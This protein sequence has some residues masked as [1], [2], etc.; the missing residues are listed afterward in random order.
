M[1]ISCTDAVNWSRSGDLVCDEVSSDHGC[2]GGVWCRCDYHID[3]AEFQRY[4]HNLIFFPL[5]SA[6]IQVLK[7]QTRKPGDP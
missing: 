6:T 2:V 4:Q 1:Q 7:I 5:Y 3:F